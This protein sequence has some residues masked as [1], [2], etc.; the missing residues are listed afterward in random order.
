MARQ[1]EVEVI[2]VEAVSVGAE[3]GGKRPAGA[4]MD[5]PQKRTLGYVA[6]PTRKHGDLSSIRQSEGR[7]VKGIGQAMLRKYTAGDPV[8]GAAGVGGD[9]FQL[10][11]VRAEEA[12]GCRHHRR[13]DPVIGCRHHRALQGRLGFELDRAVRRRSDVERLDGTARSRATECAALRDVGVVADIAG[14]EA[15]ALLVGTPRLFFGDEVRL[16]A[17]ARYLEQ[18]R[19]RQP[20][21]YPPTQHEG[22]YTQ[23]DAKNWSTL[24]IANQQNTAALCFEDV[25]ELSNRS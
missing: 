4:S 13:D 19:N 18:R 1:V 22:K 20:E 16:L 2:A 21:F 15:A 5:S 9:N 24:T 6:V 12:A 10:D 25:A 11:D 7:D 23:S 17:A 8:A 3:Y 14:G